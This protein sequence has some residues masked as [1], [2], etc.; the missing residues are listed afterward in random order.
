MI[1]MN[2]LR[3]GYESEGIAIIDGTMSDRLARDLADRALEF[4]HQQGYRR[5]GV[6]SGGGRSIYLVLDGLQVEKHFPELTGYYEAVRPLVEAVTSRVTILSP[7]PRSA[8][9]VKVYAMSDSGQGWHFDSN[10]VSGL[11]YLTEGGQPTR[12]CPA[13]I[14]D[15]A[16]CEQ[17]REIYPKRGRL[18]IFRGRELLHCVPSG[19]ELRVTCPLNYYFP[20]DTSRPTWMDSAVYNNVDPP[21]KK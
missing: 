10:P 6:A 21:P 3:A 2:N 4:A 1:Q 11:L 8:A 16:S 14:T 7:Y 19:R 13:G 15:H 9:N 5:D 20:E 18:A 12:L 17:F